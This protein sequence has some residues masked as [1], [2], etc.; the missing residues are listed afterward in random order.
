ML[1]FTIPKT[2][3]FSNGMK[4]LDMMPAGYD[5]TYVKE[6]FNTLGENGRE[7]YL[8]NQIPVDMVYPLLFGISY[9]LMMVF[10]IKKLDKLNTK[11][12]YLSF[13]PMI[14]GIS[15]YCENIGIISMLNN[16]PNFTENTVNLTSV[17]SM[18]KSISTTVFFISLFI[19]LIL[20]LKSFLNNKRIN[21]EQ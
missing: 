21:K 10:F 20:L 19:I 3:N 15:D 14:A 1:G 4:L 5:Y 16:F 12:M 6:L 8:T 18:I 13:L 7:V 17:F 9:S 2:M 11:Y